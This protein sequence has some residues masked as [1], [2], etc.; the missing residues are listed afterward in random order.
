MY[1]VASEYNFANTTWVDVIMDACTQAL[2][3]LK[4]LCI[5]NHFFWCIVAAFCFLSPITFFVDCIVWFDARIES[6]GELNGHFNRNESMSQNAV[7]EENKCLMLLVVHYYSADECKN[8]DNKLFCKWLFQ[9]QIPGQNQPK[10]FSCRTF[11]QSKT[12]QIDWQ[13]IVWYWSFTNYVWYRTTFNVFCKS[14]V[15]CTKC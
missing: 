9:F 13:W 5:W 1:I 8:V 4:Q 14:N 10:W 3:N 15:R 11:S 12:I 6:Y 7:F 2:K